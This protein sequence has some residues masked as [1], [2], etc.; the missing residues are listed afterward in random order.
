[1][2]RTMSCYRRAARST[3]TKSVKEE[4]VAY[5]NVHLLTMIHAVES[6]MILL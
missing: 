4:N 2:A 1:M 6:R 5:L 3:S